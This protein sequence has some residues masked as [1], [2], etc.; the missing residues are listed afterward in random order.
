[1]FGKIAPYIQADGYP[2][3][4][5]VWREVHYLVPDLSQRLKTSD[6]HRLVNFNS[7]LFPTTLWLQQPTIAAE[8][9]VVRSTNVFI[10]PGGGDQFFNRIL[11]PNQI[12]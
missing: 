2:K 5:T 3:D 4:H 8:C 9:K 11:A 7:Q 1:M 10:T 6:K 12:T